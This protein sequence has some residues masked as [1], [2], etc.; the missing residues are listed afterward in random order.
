MKGCGRSYGDFA[1][2]L[3]RSCVTQES[4]NWINN[5]GWVVEVEAISDSSQEFLMRVF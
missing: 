3:S 2:A 4:E 5:L 1:E